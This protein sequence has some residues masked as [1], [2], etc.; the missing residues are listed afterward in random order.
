M[1]HNSLN[2]PGGRELWLIT[3][4]CLHGILGYMCMQ[5]VCVCVPLSS[6]MQ[7]MQC[8]CVPYFNQHRTGG[9]QRQ[10][11]LMQAIAPHPPVNQLYTLPPSAHQTCN[12]CHNGNHEQVLTQWNSCIIETAMYCSE[13]RCAHTHTHTHNSI[14]VVYRHHSGTHPPGRKLT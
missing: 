6:V 1:S 13:D 4:L 11:C 10:K 12:L 2:V 9:I 5:C 8:V 14:K 3:T 7:C